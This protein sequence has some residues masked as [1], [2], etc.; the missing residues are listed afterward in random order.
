MNIENNHDMSKKYLSMYQLAENKNK[1]N[2]NEYK[3]NPKR[4]FIKTFIKLMIKL[5]DKY[6]ETNNENDK[7]ILKVIY[8]IISNINLKKIYHIYHNKIKN[9]N[10]ID[11]KI[12]K[13]S[14]D[15]I[16]TYI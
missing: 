10:L 2:T 12:L 5:L 14:K 1:T 8:Q 15:N 9:S 16:L 4:I 3:K 7:F 6:K 13:Y 11:K